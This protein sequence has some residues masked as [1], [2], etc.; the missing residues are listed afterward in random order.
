MIGCLYDGRDSIFTCIESIRK[1][2]GDNAFIVV[3]DSNSADTS[4]LDRLPNDVVSWPVTNSNYTTGVVWTVYR[5]LL[6]DD[7]YFLHD[8]IKIIG[9]IRLKPDEEVKVF[10][11]WA[12]CDW[13]HHRW[14]SVQQYSWVVNQL[15]ENTTLR[16]T[17]KPFRGVFGEMLFVRRPVLDALKSVGFDR[18]LP[19]EKWQSCGMER[20][21]GMALNLLGY[22]FDAFYEFDGEEHL[23]YSENANKPLCKIEGTG[24]RQ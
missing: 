3:V 22:R 8:N 7:Y 15:H 20:A 12:T 9:D 18:I 21:W 19:T 11:S 4:Y 13:P 16:Y 5:D 14:D 2:Y 10:G 1:V 17:G 24:N 23:K 6:A